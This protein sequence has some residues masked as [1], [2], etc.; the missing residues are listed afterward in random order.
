MNKAPA[1]RQRACLVR[2]QEECKG[3]L[4]SSGSN[5][6]RIGRPGSDNMHYSTARTM[7]R[8]QIRVH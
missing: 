1:D 2:V 3:H 8:S 6:T 4:L 5:N 7:N